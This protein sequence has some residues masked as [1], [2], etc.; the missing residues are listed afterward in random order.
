MPRRW[1]RY[2]C[3]DIAQGLVALGVDIRPMRDSDVESF[4][5][6][7][8]RAWAP[9]LASIP[10]TVGPQILA[11]YYGYDWRS[12]HTRPVDAGAYRYS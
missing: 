12:H 1:I 8:M 9:V 4:V 10:N 7:S 11:Y 3:P 5:A 6:Q 2:A